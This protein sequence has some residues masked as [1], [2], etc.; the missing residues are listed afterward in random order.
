L[1]KRFTLAQKYYQAGLGGEA[2][3]LVSEILNDGP[4]PTEVL[5]LATALRLEAGACEETIGLAD[6]ILALDSQN[7]SA[8]VA[9]TQ[10]LF[11]LGRSAEAE[12]AYAAALTSDQA[13]PAGWNN[14]GNLL[15]E[16]GRF[17]DAR[18]AFARAIAEAPH[19][20]QAHNNLGVTLAGQGEYAAA[21]AC[22][23][24][25]LRC[26]PL[27]L[28]ARVN[29]GVALLEQGL[30]EEAQ[31]EFSAV[32]RADPQNREAA[33][34]ALYAALYT[35]EDPRVV[36]EAHVA[37]GKTLPSATFV[38]PENGRSQRLRVGYI[39]PD[40]RRH[41]VS[42]FIEPLLNAHDPE[43]ID[44][45]CYADVAASD[46]VTGRLKIRSKH[47]RDIYGV[48]DAEVL[49]LIREDKLDI[50][51][52]LAGHTKGNRLGV[53]AERAAPVQVSALGYPATTGV[54]AMDF[55]LCDAVTDPPAHNH[56]SVE[57]IVHLS[58]GMHCYQPPVQTPDVGALPAGKAGYVTF[59]SFNKL[60][61]VSGV[62]VAMWANVLNALP[63]ARLIV[64]SKALTEE[65]THARLLARFAAYGIVA[66]RLDLRPWVPGDVGHLDL[67]NEIDIA[68]DTY[69]YN[70]T[71]TTCEALWMGVPVLTL[72][73]HGHAAR[74]AASLLTQAGL[75]DWIAD[76]A[77]AFTSSAVKHAGNLAALAALR[78]GMRA[79]V[80]ASPLCD[81]Q[82]YAREVESAYRAMLTGSSAG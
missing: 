25:A 73:G 21:A 11:R 69:P 29:L 23:R 43:H 72:R 62:T 28:G 33:D 31:S 10:A 15:D 12:R 22:Y 17:A 81:A 26:E 53:F 66:E 51:V 54:G 50:L 68:L 58:S 78:Q 57:R 2:W 39:S 36:Y 64:K 70:G 30:A 46:D 4:A 1:D 76:T 19:F 49:A 34:N 41:S 71:T 44:V 60:A 40:F 42:F 5:A 18:K 8:L 37:W 16:L 77:H 7:T 9:K 47:W 75:Q 52:D 27:N 74:V 3:A 82:S 67:Y 13:H 38:P 59:G 32:R 56:I 24:E 63:G 79:R 14:L 45:F 61:K 6:R 80:K 20:S 55:R 48:N 65:S 35:E